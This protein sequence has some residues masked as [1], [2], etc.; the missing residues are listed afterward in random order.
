MVLTLGPVKKALKLK[1][2]PFECN[3]NFLDG[4]NATLEKCFISGSFEKQ[5]L[6]FATAE[7]K[8]E[9]EIATSCIRCG[10]DVSLKLIIPFREEFSTDENDDC[11]ALAGSQ[12]EIDQMVIDLILT[13]FPT[14]ILCKKDCLGRCSKCGKNLNEGKCECENEIKLDDPANPFNELKKLKGNIGGNKNGSS[15]S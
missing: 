9:C 1:E 2:A 7:G 14:K 11:Y 4:L 12:I 5:T 8:I 15:K 10:T 6:N 13:N 3:I